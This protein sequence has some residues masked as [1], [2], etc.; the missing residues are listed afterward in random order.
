MSKPTT[1]EIK[2]VQYSDKNVLVDKKQKWKPNTFT[3]L[4]KCPQCS[5]KQHINTLKKVMS[6][7]TVREK[8][9][10]THL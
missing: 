4:K 3:K 9:K 2:K 5:Q 6:S 1:E 10:K 7:S 8:V